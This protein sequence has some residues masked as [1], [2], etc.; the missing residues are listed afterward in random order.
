MPEGA[1]TVNIPDNRRK[2]LYYYLFILGRIFKCFYGP[3][4]YLSSVVGDAAA[5]KFFDGLS[6]VGQYPID[7]TL[8]IKGL[9]R[10][11]PRPVIQP[12]SP[13]MVNFYFLFLSQAS[14]TATT[15]AT[16]VIRLSTR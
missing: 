10:Y 16:S 1:Y 14:M 3:L 7:P 4:R 11:V 6:P 5:C 12:F 15:I 2:R 9:G 13:I 8:V